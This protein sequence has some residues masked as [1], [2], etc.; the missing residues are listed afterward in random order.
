RSD[1]GHRLRFRPAQ[2]GAVAVLP[3]ALEGR[4]AVELVLR[5]VVDGLHGDVLAVA[6]DDQA[7]PATRVLQAPGLLLRQVERLPHTGDVV[8]VLLVQDRGGHAGEARHRL[9]RA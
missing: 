9:L 1:R 2:A 4:G 6:G 3:A 5:L 7:L 8:R